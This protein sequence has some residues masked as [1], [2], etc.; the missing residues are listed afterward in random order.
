MTGW[1]FV[2]SDAV[3]NG[4]SLSSW[5]ARGVKCAQSLPPKSNTKSKSRTRT[6][7]VAKH[8]DAATARSD[9]TQT[10]RAGM[11]QAPVMW[12]TGRECVRLF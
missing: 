6:T 2:A 1:V 7:Q 11:E 3:A 10:G 9:A 4:R 12:S 8:A 5:V